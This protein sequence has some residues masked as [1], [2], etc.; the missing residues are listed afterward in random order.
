[1]GGS[2]AVRLAHGHSE[3]VE[4]V[5]ELRAFGW[6][7]GGEGETSESGQGFIAFVP[8]RRVEK[9]MAADDAA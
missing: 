9:L 5:E 4:L 7:I 3:G 6:R 1:M 8:W 2:A